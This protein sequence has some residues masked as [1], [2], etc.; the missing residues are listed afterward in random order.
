MKICVIGGANMDICATTAVPFVAR[1]SN[2]G[3]VRIAPGGVGRNIA[4][5]LALL[6][7]EVQF[8]TVFG[9]D[10]FGRLLREHCESVGIGTKL[11]R[12]VRGARNACFVSVNDSDGEMLGGVADMAVTGLMTPEWLEARLA[13]I[14]NFDAVV[15]DTNLPAET[16]GMLIASCEP[17]LYIDAV[18][19]A[20]AQRL[21]EALIM[22]RLHSNPVFALKCNRLEAE[23]L[24][25]YESGR[26]LG[27][28]V[29]RLYVS[30]GSEGVAVRENG[31]ETQFAA[32]PSKVIVNATGAGDA[33]FA[34]IVHAGP[35][36][37][38]ADAARFGLEC[39]RVAMQT[40]EAV[41]DK[42]KNLKYE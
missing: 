3:T 34:G 18:S 41:N 35:G 26:T 2:P 6:G 19:S 9:D 21:K 42:I 4:H 22:G 13:K 10:S 40:A 8:V 29:E 12:V 27:A 1:D 30:K 11:S 33:M 36:A 7:D 16:L 23:V 25:L 20:K 37:S 31:E 24:G 15:A 28:K 38:A 39:A 17:P 5:N 32:L 14:N